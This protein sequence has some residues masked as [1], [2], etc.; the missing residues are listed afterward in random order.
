MD[1]QTDEQTNWSSDRF[2]PN[3]A[4]TWNMFLNQT[5]CTLYIIQNA[6]SIFSL[7]LVES[8]TKATAM[9]YFYLLLIFFGYFLV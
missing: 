3:G 4:A 8:K 6:W 9:V 1:R 7:D 5:I 2:Q